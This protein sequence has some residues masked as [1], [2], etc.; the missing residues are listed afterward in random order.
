MCPRRLADRQ[1][2]GVADVPVLAA[3]PA[4]VAVKENP[5]DFRAVGQVDV[6]DFALAPAHG[7][8]ENGVP[9]IQEL[10]DLLGVDVADVLLFHGVFLSGLSA[11]S[12]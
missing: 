3:L 11:L 5:E 2:D 12:V 8:R 9:L 4:V 6:R 1:A 10:G 7:V